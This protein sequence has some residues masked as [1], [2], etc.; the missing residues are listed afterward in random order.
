MMFLA[1]LGLII[2]VVLVT[3]GGVG[4]V[5][6]LGVWALSVWFFVLSVRAAARR[7]AAE[8]A[9][10]TTPEAVAEVPVP[11]SS[12]G[13]QKVVGEQHYPHAL[14]SVVAGRPVAP[15][16]EWER[17]L[18]VTAYLVPEPGN[19]HDP[20]AVAVKV[21]VDGGGIRI[22]YLPRED[23]VRYQPLLKHLTR[24]GRVG[25]CDAGIVQGAAGLAVFLYLAQPAE[26]MFQNDPPAATRLPAERSCAVTDEGHHQDV[27]GRFRTDGMVWA[28]LHPATVERG[29][30]A[31]QQTIEVR[32]DSERVGVLSASQGDRYRQILTWST[33]PTV[34][35][36]AQVYKGSRGIEARVFMP[37]VD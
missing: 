31:G 30:Y 16:G 21:L 24:L 9:Q 27:L 36:E 6:G 23:A 18:R 4:P 26:C 1:V 20:N 34:A 29:K 8:I 14:R 15:A 11:L 19:P 2:G 32:I 22:A 5:F 12:R 17:A 10:Q 3:A 35:V 25:I 13:R 33:A 28:T 37:K 7:R